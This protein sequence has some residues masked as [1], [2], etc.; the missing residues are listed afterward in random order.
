LANAAAS[1]PARVMVRVVRL[2][3]GEAQGRVE[4]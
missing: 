1:G 2:G 3:M 4:G